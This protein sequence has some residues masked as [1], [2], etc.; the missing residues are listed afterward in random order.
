ML[1]RLFIITVSMDCIFCIGGKSVFSTVQYTLPV[2][3]VSSV[4]GT[5]EA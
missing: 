1:Q 4:R 5:F 2:Y 3:S